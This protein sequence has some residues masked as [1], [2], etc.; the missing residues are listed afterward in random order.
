M[1]ERARDAL[2]GHVAVRLVLNSD[3]DVV[4]FPIHDLCH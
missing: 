4:L 1:M 2:K 3:E